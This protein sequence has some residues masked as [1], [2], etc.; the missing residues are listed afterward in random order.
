MKIYGGGVA[1][2]SS[3][4]N[5]TVASGTSFPANANVAEMFYRIDTNKLFVNNPTDWIELYLSNNIKTYTQ[6]SLADTW[7]IT[8]NM[9]TTDLLY[10][11][12]VY[13]NSVLTPILPN[14][15]TFVSNNQIQFTF[16]VQKT[17][18][19]VL[20]SNAYL[21]V[22]NTYKHT[23]SV[24]SNSWIIQHNLNPKDVL[25]NVYIDIGSSVFK[26]INPL[27]FTFTDNNTIH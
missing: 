5:L 25:F 12:Y 19:V 6:S 10:A 27:D 15:T 16:S 11:V 23:Q 20:I 21:I 17:G 1:E 14:T 4:T 24:S 9:G 13:D 22:N 2:G 8:H 26:P 18:K 7:T 3:I